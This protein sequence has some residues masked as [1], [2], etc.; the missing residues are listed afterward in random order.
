MLQNQSVQFDV[1]DIRALL[2][3]QAAIV[4][5]KEDIDKVLGRLSACH[6]SEGPIILLIRGE[7]KGVGKA[8]VAEMV[9]D[10]DQFKCYSRIWINQSHML[11]LYEI[12]KYTISQVSAG[13]EETTGRGSKDDM[14]YITNRLHELLNG[15]KVLVVLH[16]LWDDASQWKRL[17]DMLSVGGMSSTQVIVIATVDTYEQDKVAMEI[18][19]L[20][21]S[22]TV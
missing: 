17:K 13:E 4:G 21:S 10:N 16:N 8:T 9:F 18:K 14:V 12:G 11:D 22:H 5:R 20:V 19:F 15:K 1:R 7:Q 2:Q 3:A 6:S